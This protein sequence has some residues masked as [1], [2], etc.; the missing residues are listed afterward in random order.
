MLLD[1]VDREMGQGPEGQEKDRRGKADW[2]KAG[3]S[4]QPGG[5]DPARLILIGGYRLMKNLSIDI[6]TYS[7]Q[8][9]AKCGVYRYAESPEFKILLFGY[10]VDHGPATTVDLASGEEIPQEILVALTDESVIKFAFNCMFE[11][12]C[13]STYLRRRHPEYFE[14]YSI[15]EDTVSHYLDPASW[16]CSMVWSAYRGLPLSLAQVG[17]VLGLSDQK[18][19]EGKDLIKFFSVPCTPSKANGNRTRNLPIDAPD[20]WAIFKSYNI[21]DV[22]VEVQIQER[23]SKYPVPDSV[24]EEYRIDQEINDRG[25]RV[26]MQLVK[27]AIA[28][29][30]HTH[31]K[32]MTEMTELTGLD[33]PGSVQQLK[34]YLADNGVV[35]DTLGKKA[36]ATLIDEVPDDVRQVLEL[37]QQT[38]KSSIK[39]YQTME[40]AACSDDRIR[41]MFQFMGAPRT[42]RFA[43]RLVQL[44]NLKRNSMPD[45]A[46]ARELVRTGNFAAMELLY[47]SVPEVLSELIRTALVP[48]P[49]YKFYVADYSAV[50]ARCL[51]FLAKEQWRIDSFAANKDIYCES[52]SQMFHCKVEKHGEN[53][54]LRQRG[55]IAEL[56]LGYGGSTGALKAMGALE[57]GLDESELQPLVDAW[58]STNPNIVDFWWAVDAAAMKAVRMKTTTETHGFKFICRNGM[59][60]ITL[61]SGRVLS[62]VKPRIGLNQFGNDCVTYMGLDSTKHW[63]RIE[64]YGPKVVENITQAICRDILCN[65]MKTLQH[66][67]IC[68]HIHDE[69]VI[70]CRDDVSL[71]EICKQMGQDAC[72]DSRPCFCEADGLHL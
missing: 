51:S 21:R 28:I 46:E 19:K 45:L 65:A 8:D 55:K 63:S 29:D 42:G 22:E 5:S 15:P 44:Q 13:I 18:M 30:E 60:F 54:H 2:G 10:S 68:A 38:A 70:E 9:L 69:L 37:R 72:L 56:A 25:T 53:A 16:H 61:P 1:S 66:C 20:K 62:Y 47:D 59:L 57:M 11:R 41:G 39:K 58:R 4:I 43:G 35:T 24:W 40:R 50:E 6:E 14:S 26:D 49:G 36:V 3:V 52:A 48:K 71:E 27:N 64:T 67:F 31:D 33:N 17:E 23:L 7:D 12:V 34:G 32:F